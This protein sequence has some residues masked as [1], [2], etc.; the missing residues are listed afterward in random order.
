MKTDAKKADAT[1]GD[2][3]HGGGGPRIGDVAEPYEYDA[4]QDREA[5]VGYRAAREGAALFER[6]GSTLV[7]VTGS[8]RLPYLNSLSTN[9][10]VDLDPGR[11]ARAFLLV[12]T[13]G[14]VLADFI[15]CE[16]GAATWLECQG[17]SGPT[18][19]ELLGKYYF[20]QDVAV[21]DRA[22]AGACCL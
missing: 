16:T 12:P 11:A 18:V 15:A 6:P 2:A 13:K 8:E 20:G 1:Q 9:K 22:D 21:H 17:G 19:T 4:A 10:L 3:T 5:P 14:R 7:E